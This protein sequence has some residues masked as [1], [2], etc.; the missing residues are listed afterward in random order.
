MLTLAERLGKDGRDRVS[1]F[2]KY[3]GQEL[4]LDMEGEKGKAILQQLKDW[5]KTELAGR[6]SERFTPDY[7]ASK[8]LEKRPKA[9]AKPSEDAS[10]AFDPWDPKNGLVDPR[11]PWERFPSPEEQK[12]NPQLVKLFDPLRL[13]RELEVARAEWEAERAK[14]PWRTRIKEAFSSDD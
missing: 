3:A 1:L 10:A 12:R 2:L 7:T 9:T 8:Q 5:R 11:A 4:R 6:H 13:N 14:H